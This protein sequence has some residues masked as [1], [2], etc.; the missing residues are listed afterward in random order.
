MVVLV[1]MARTR[2]AEAVPSSMACTDTSLNRCVWL[3]RPGAERIGLENSDKELMV[4][5]AKNP[6]DSIAVVVFNEGNEAKNINLSL[7]ENNVNIQ[8]SSQAIQTIVIPN[9]N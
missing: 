6:D 4:T 7:G 5:A 9:I 3:I 1:F 2:R 8:I